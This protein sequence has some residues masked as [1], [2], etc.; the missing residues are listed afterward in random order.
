ML[1]EGDLLREPAGVGARLQ[2]DHQR[3]AV[4]IVGAARY[5]A[6]GHAAAT[7]GARGRGARTTRRGCARTRLPGPRSARGDY[8]PQL[9]RLLAGTD[10]AVLDQAVVA[11][12]GGQ[13]AL[14]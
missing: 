4:A 8:R 7:G 2:A 3:V 12:E 10:R 1:G 9:D 13:L 14:Q 11:A 6:N 5:P